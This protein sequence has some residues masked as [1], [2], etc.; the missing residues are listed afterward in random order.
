MH[1]I[2]MQNWIRNKISLENFSAVCMY[3]FSNMTCNYGF[4]KIRQTESCSQHLWLDSKR[5]AGAQ[6]QGCKEP[7]NSVALLYFPPEFFKVP[8]NKNYKV[9]PFS[10]GTKRKRSLHWKH[11]TS[12][13]NALEQS[14]LNFSP[15]VNNIWKEINLYATSDLTR[16][17]LCAEQLAHE[18]AFE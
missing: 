4:V 3:I 17:L 16:Q 13:N 2:L 14:I 10:V 18:L 8:F 5:T 6:G 15:N 1:E 11:H 12:N 7:G 9:V